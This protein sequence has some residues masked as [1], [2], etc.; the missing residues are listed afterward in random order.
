MERHGK[1]NIHEKG[2][3][4]EVER[5]Y[6][7]AS[8]SDAMK[9]EERITKLFPEAHLIGKYSEQS[10]FYPKMTK[11]EAWKPLWLALRNRFDGYKMLNKIRQI[12]DDALVIMRFRSRKS[13]VEKKYVLTF[14]ASEDPLHGI[15]R[16][17]EETEDVSE[18]LVEFL[19]ENN[20]EPETVWNSDRHLYQINE[21]TKIDVQNVTGYGWTAEI[22]S[23]DIQ[24]VQE[25]AT[26]LGGLQPPSQ[27]LLGVMYAQ[28]K[29]HWREYCGTE[30]KIRHFSETDWEEIESASKEELVKNHID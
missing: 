15:E 14:K 4:I 13:P 28:Y 12:P 6:L 26:K 11:K 2:P 30:G 22:E 27:E 24:T 10:Y 25:I 19:S 3:N 1:T 7:L 5:K 23:D 20:I 9:L 16:I 17:E 21:K 8:E 18:K 29:A